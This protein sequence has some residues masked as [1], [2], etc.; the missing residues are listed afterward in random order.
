MTAK[1]HSA[2]PITQAMKVLRKPGEPS[3]C[4]VSDQSVGACE[5]CAAANARQAIR[6]LL[7]I[8]PTSP[9]VTCMR[10]NLR[11]NDSHR[12][13]ANTPTEQ[14]MIVLCQQKPPKQLSTDAVC[15]PDRNR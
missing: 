11:V 13:S 2:L 6:T 8:L 15:A 10:S 12:C 1:N 14:H 9:E 3:R 4:G 5:R 7:T